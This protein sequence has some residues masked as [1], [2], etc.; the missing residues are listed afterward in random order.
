MKTWVDDDGIMFSQVP[1]HDGKP[2]RWFN[3]GEWCTP[4][5]RF[6]M[7]WYILSI[8]GC[9]RITARTAAILGNEKE[10][11]EYQA[12]AERTKDAFHKRFYD[13]E[14]AHLRK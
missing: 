9:V 12:L 2:L 8:S 14:K 5:N 6:P 1:G 10:A 11:A 4:G 7:K 13:E 3:L